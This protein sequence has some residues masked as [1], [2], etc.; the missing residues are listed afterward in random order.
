MKLESFQYNCIVAPLDFSETPEEKAR[1]E[2]HKNITWF[3]LTNS[4]SRAL[5]NSSCTAT[6]LPSHEPSK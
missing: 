2:L 3:F 4:E 5:Q 1:G 6:Y